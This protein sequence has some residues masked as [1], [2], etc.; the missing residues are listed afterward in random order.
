LTFL[1]VAAAV[2]VRS[3]VFSY[4]R[5]KSSSPG[6]VW[7]RRGRGGGRV[8]AS[9]NARSVLAWRRR[10]DR[11]GGRDALPDGRVHRASRLA[12]RAT[13]AHAGDGFGWRPQRHR[14][15]DATAPTPLRSACCFA[16]A[17]TQQPRR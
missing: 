17:A 1:L 3:P 4:A 12:G 15:A 5:T 2:K 6:P 7:D 11:R 10:L 16:L 8:E 13:S 9:G 14:R